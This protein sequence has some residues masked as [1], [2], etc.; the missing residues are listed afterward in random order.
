MDESQLARAKMLA[1]CFAKNGNLKMAFRI[2]WNTYQVRKVFAAKE[3]HNRRVERLRKK[4]QDLTNDML[5]G[6]EKLKHLDP[7]DN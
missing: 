1:K 4:T 3:R 6:I 5:V 7:I 2:V